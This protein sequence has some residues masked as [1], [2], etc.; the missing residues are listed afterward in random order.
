MKLTHAVAI[1][2]LFGSLNVYADGPAFFSGND[3]HRLLISDIDAERS[4]AMGFVI[5][6]VDSHMNKKIFCLPNGITTGQ[7]IDVVKKN[8]AQNPEVRHYSAYS[9]AVVAIAKAFPC[10]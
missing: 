2:C 6:V 9:N 4:R 10:K 5:G 8:D 1:S 3:L 7:L